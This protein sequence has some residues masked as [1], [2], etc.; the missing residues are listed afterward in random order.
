MS[1]LG[2]ADESSNFLAT[3]FRGCEGRAVSEIKGMLKSFGQISPK[4]NRTPALGVLVGFS[5]QPILEVVPQLARI[6]EEEP[7]RIRYLLRLIPLEK[8]VHSLNEL[9]EE[10]GQLASKIPDADSFRVTFD[11]R[12]SDLNGSEVIEKVASQIY[13]RVDLDNP[14]WIV[15]VQ[16]VEQWIGIGVL[17]PMDILSVIKIRRGD[18]GKTTFPLQ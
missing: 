16:V 12:R 6:V 1:T 8:V 7:W 3:T 10:V 18:Y 11:R 4:L 2:W 15:M 17:K 14:D 9:L 13:R 5:E